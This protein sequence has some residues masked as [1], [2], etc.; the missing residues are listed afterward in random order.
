MRYDA[1][2]EFV[3]TLVC[4]GV[5]S[6]VIGLF[7]EDDAEIM[8]YIKVVLSLCIAASIIPSV[9]GMLGK[10]PLEDILPEE[11]GAAFE[12][13][14]QNYDNYVIENARKELALTLK[15]EIF[16]KTGINV[17]Y[18]NIQFSEEEKEEKLYLDIASVEIELDLDS[19]EHA[20]SECVY[21]LVGIYPEFLIRKQNGG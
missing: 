18:C 1:M 8:K 19:H 10:L 14:Q 20:V 3:I 5:S 6:G 4:A 11:D 16:E 21:S 15:R 12:E 2:R 7:F 17:P 13:F 9:Y